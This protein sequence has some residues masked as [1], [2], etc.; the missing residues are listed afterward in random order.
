MIV[1]CDCDCVSGMSGNELDEL[2]WIEFI[3]E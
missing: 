1:N 2:N 3:N